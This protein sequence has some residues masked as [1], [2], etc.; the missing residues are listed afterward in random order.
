[1]KKRLIFT[2]KIFRKSNTLNGL[3]KQSKKFLEVLH[4]EVLRE[5]KR[6]NERGKDRE[7][8]LS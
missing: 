3:L 1:M 5:R 7:E 4:K 2:L 8:K 6:A